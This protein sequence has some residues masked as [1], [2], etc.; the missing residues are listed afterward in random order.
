M[1]NILASLAICA[2]AK[3]GFLWVFVSKGEREGHA[4]GRAPHREND[5][6]LV[7]SHDGHGMGAPLVSETQGLRPMWFSLLN[8]NLRTPWADIPKGREERRWIR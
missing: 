1:I 5:P 8:Q 4:L 6:S 7:E 3:L 2:V